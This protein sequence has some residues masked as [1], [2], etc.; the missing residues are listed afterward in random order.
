MPFLKRSKK[1]DELT[2]CLNHTKTSI[3][4]IS[5][6]TSNKSIKFFSTQELDNAKVIKGGTNGRPKFG[7][8]GFEWGDTMNG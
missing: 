2:I 8:R 5:K 7:G 4:K 1:V 6:K 3:M